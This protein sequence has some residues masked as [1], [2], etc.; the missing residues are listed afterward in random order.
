MI[1]NA[2]SADKVYILKFCKNTFSWGDYIQDVWD[3]WFSEGSLLVAEES[4]PVGICH[5]VFFKEQVW[6]EGIRVDPTFRRKG[7]ASK[8]VNKIESLSKGKQIKFSF[9][10]IDTKNKP[11]LEMAKILNYKIFQTWNFYSLSPKQNIHHQISFGNVISENQFDHY[12]KSWRWIPLDQQKLNFL[13]SKNC[14]IYSGNEDNKTIAILEDSEHF[15]NT[16]I[17]TLYAGAENNINN[18][19]SFLQ[20]YGFEKNY[21][22]LQ[23]LTK[24][25]LPNYKGLDLRLS[26]HLMQKLLS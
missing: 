22:R 2:T 19:I 1:R 25:D 8:L 18:M 5:G 12:V 23:I 13:N 7:V 16:L 17:V 20:N 9:M 21:Q 11:S 15:K 3:Y 26:F 4:V 6:I 24:E 14:I 10:L